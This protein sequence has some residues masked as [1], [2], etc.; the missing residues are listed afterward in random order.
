[1][2]D[3]RAPPRGFTLIE[4]MIVVAIIGILA[5]MALPM[6]Q[7]ATL[8][9]RS[10]ERPQVAR[11]I[12]NSVGEVYRQTGSTGF[13]GD[14]N[15]PLPPGT[16]KRNIDWSRPGWSVL[17]DKVSITVE[18]GAYYSYYFA[19]WDGANA[20]MTVV[21]TGDLD[22]DGVPSIKTWSFLRQQDA[23]VLVSEDPP[24]GQEDL[25]VF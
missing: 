13:V 12:A 17:R 5:S 16:M 18:G 2:T 24:A 3:R 7:N 21:A 15:P 9:A 6:F 23:F 8:R 22:G 19:A 1:M 4:L 10:T 25:G 14:F 20:G 11:A